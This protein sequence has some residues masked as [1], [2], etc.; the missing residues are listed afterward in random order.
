[1]VTQIVAD[2]VQAPSLEILDIMTDD[3]LLVVA[4]YFHISITVLQRKSNE[5]IKQAVIAGLIS[6]VL[7]VTAASADSPPWGLP[8]SFEEK[9]SLGVPCERELE[10]LRLIA[11]IE[12]RKHQVEKMRL[13]IELQRL[14]LIREGKLSG[15]ANHSAGETTVPPKL[16]VAK[17]VRL[18]PP[19][20]ESDVD[21]FFQRIY[22]LSYFH[23]LKKV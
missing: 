19:F 2:F 4:E 23:I 17:N 16:N 20:N 14:E 15:Q 7:P 12:N 18:V 6:Q 5:A 11:E 3:D 1:M 13:D 8:S 22:L 10:R 9:T 21:V